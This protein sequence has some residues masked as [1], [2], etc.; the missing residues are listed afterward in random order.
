M[1]INPVGK[2]GSPF[3]WGLF[4]LGGAVNKKKIFT[5]HRNKTC[6]YLQTMFVFRLAVP[7]YL[8]IEISDANGVVVRSSIA[9]SK[10]E[11]CAVPLTYEVLCGVLS[12]Y[13]DH[14]M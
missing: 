3:F 10:I 1:K 14:K 5:I 13:S 6:T 7:I 8:T 4:F 2:K 11:E 9:K 12:K